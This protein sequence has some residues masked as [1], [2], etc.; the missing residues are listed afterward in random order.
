MIERGGEEL[1]EEISGRE[2]KKKI[3]EGGRR[4]RDE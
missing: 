3:R 2:G 4:G 1:V